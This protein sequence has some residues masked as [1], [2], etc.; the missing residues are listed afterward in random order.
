MNYGC[1]GERLGHSFSRDIH[2]KLD[3]YD[4]ILKEIP[5]DGLDEF[6][7]RRDFRA[8]NVTIP[9]KQA[10]IPYLDH[11]S[12]TA[13]RIGAV[14]TIVKRNGE[15]WGYNT[16]FGGM[17]ALIARCG[18]ELAGR[19]VLICGTGGT[20]RTALA[21]AESLGA[22]EVYRLSR[23]G[24][25]GALRYEEAYE[26]HSDAQ[27]LINTTPCGMFPHVD[28][29]A[30]DPGRFPKLEGAVDAVYNPLR[31]A[32]IRAVC[33]K[34]AV[35]EGGLYMLVMQA[36]LAWEIFTGKK[37][38]EEKAESVYRAMLRERENIVLIGMPAS[39]KS[40][41]GAI[42]AEKLG[43]E[44]IDTD[45]LIVERAG[46]SIPAIF[47]KYGEEHFRRLESEAVKEA[48][49]KTGVVIATGGGAILRSC[50]VEALRQNGRL[51]WLYRPLAELI[52]TADRPLGSS[53]AALE[54]RYEERYSLYR[55]AADERIAGMGSA[56]E[57]AEC[58]LEMFR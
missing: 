27:I 19:K 20:S 35:A 30:I 53:R 44:L 4:Y 26:R 55:A 6:M 2:G 21:V 17:K 11:I 28:G 7:R 22:G 43:R 56:A 5:R 40:S 12:E 13:Q 14:N 31:S 52:P 54:K 3:D 25:D 39:G 23:D 48:G 51:F 45:A 8:I 46:E 49:A 29:M 42:L 57:A 10:V 38:G 18:L 9:Y 34:G 47:E 15:L 37:C 50:N 58:I 1:I 16:D 24:R 36:V 33:R 32:F 41:V